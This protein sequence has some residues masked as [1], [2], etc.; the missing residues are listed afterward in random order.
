MP[1]LGVSDTPPDLNASVWAFPVV[2]LVTGLV[3][4]GVYAIVIGVGLPVTLAAIFTIGIMILMTGAMHEDGLAD[5]ADGFGGGQSIER[6]LEIMRDSNIGT[7][8]MVA[9][10]LAIALRIGSLSALSTSGVVT[11]LIIASVLSRLMMVFVMRFM[12][13]ARKDG[14]AHDAGKPSIWS[15]LV[16]SVISIGVAYYLAGLTTT[17]FV[18]LAAVLSCLIMAWIAKRQ[19]GGVT[20]DV[21]GA[22]QQVSEIS[23]LVLLVA[24]WN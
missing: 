1:R 13:P 18:L 24:L 11:G 2:G 10:V 6:K 3:G 23:I 17:A 15:V 7:Y 19:I 21:L 5:V 16:G 12:Q 4:A 20:G 8:G 14:L 22:T 9:I